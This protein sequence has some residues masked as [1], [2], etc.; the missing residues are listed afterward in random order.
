MS[1]PIVWNQKPLDKSLVKEMAFELEIP[2][3]SAAAFISRGLDSI[4]KAEIYCDMGL[5]KL[6]D[7][8]MLPDITKAIDRLSKAINNGEHIHIHGDYD[9]DGITS[10]AVIVNTLRKL[11]ANITYQ[12]PH[13]IL[14]GYDL[15][16]TT[17]EQAKSNNVDLLI[18]CDC[19]ILAFDAAKKAK[20]LGIDLIIT[21]H[22]LPSDDGELPDC[23]AV[24]NPNRKD[25]EYGFSDL[26]GV[27]VAF[28]FMWAVAQTYKL[29]KQ[30]F[31]DDTIEYVALGTVADVAPMIDEN[32]SL[33]ALG[34]EQLAA[35]K[36]QG[37][38]HLLK[39]AGINK[40]NTTSIGFFIGPR[41]NAVGRLADSM[42]AL[43]L[44]LEKDPH[45][46][47]YK[48]AQLD[49]MNKRRQDKQEQVLDE[50]RALIDES[51]LEETSIL[52]LSAKGWHPGLIGL[53][54][55]KI[56]E[57]YGRPTLICTVDADGKAKGSCRST[58]NFHILQALKSPGCFELF[59]KVGGHSFAA[60]FE[61]SAD[62]IP[63]LRE[64][65]NNY[66]KQITSDGI[67]A[68]KKIDIDA[69][70]NQ[71]D[72]T[73]ET[74]KAIAKLAPFGSQN[75]EPIFI[76]RNLMLAEI[77]TVGAEAK[78]MKLKIYAGKYDNQW[79]NALWWRNGHLAGHFSKDTAVDVVF[80]LSMEEYLGR[81]NLTMIIEDMRL[82]DHK[83]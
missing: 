28:K 50:A 16:P 63:L 11:N 58:R 74:W 47:A 64:N 79:I 31:I 2:E 53:V 32:R 82:S 61:L 83:E 62:K 65:L 25:S 51:T 30:E 72:I 4:E 80:K 54:A 70:I 24:I 57:E 55:G 13:R 3:P 49:T 77:G 66:A 52:V 69:K 8:W 48:A 59:N 44:M 41:I 21:D 71:M 7:P 36:K 42:T 75:P 23:V 17:V 35:T 10:V 39:V 81:T 12:V 29:N 26:A 19:G 27:G 56:A 46:A 34:C 60:G 5:H 73:T 9:V 37:I 33:V 15:K 68:I 1:I 78:H 20:E 45:Q 76:A 14:D 18:S 43:E 38:A 22:H 67:E 6:H 40:V